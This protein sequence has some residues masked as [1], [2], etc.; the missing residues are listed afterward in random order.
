MSQ[1]DLRSDAG[2]F[3]S[4]AVVTQAMGYELAK[5]QGLEYFE[6]SAAEQTGNLDPFHF[7]AD[8]FHR[9]YNDTVDSVARGF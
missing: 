5:Q 2:D 8:Q 6:T 3:A 4:R 9:K 1:V 7:I